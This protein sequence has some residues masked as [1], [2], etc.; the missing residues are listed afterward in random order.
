[1]LELTLSPQSGSMNSA[2]DYM[3]E[4]GI[5]GDKVIFMEYLR[6]AIAQEAGMMIGAIYGLELELG[7]KYTNLI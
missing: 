1:M 3:Y 7:T 5:Y 2:T 6:T 4:L